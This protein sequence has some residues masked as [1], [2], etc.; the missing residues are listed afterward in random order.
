MRIGGIFFLQDLVFVIF[1][2]GMLVSS[3]SSGRKIF[4]SPL[5]YTPF[6][7]ISVAYFG[8]ILFDDRTGIEDTMGELKAVG[9]FALAASVLLV[10]QKYSVTRERIFRDLQNMSAIG[11]FYISVIGI[12]QFTSGGFDNV[13]KYLYELS[14]GEGLTNLEYSQQISRV[15][16][17][18]VSPL[19]LGIFLAMSILVILT[20]FKMSNRIVAFTAVLL[21]A[22]TLILANARAAIAFLLFGMVMMFFRNRN[23]FLSI[24]L[25]LMFAGVFVWMLGFLS[26]E[27][28]DRYYETAYYILSGF[29]SNLVPGNITERIFNTEI[30]WTTIFQSGYLVFGIPASVFYRS[31]H[32]Y[33]PDNQFTAFLANYGIVSFGLFVWQ[34][35]VVGYLLRCYGKARNDQIKNIHLALFLLVLGGIMVGVT[36]EVILTKR[37]RELFFTFLAVSFVPEGIESEHM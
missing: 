32:Y 13:L 2:G 22:I 3:F 1:F 30:L 10:A 34:F 37:V 8:K 21:G 27:N 16:S 4:L 11:V 7:L 29:D 28:V 17:I 31:L 5:L 36:Q 20:N 18:F 14:V 6:I 24:L 26:D 25:S 19:T 12:L 35:Y 15:T 33:S 9:L 23:R